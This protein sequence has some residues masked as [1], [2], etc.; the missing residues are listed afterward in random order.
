MFSKKLWQKAAARLKDQGIDLMFFRQ[1]SDPEGLNSR[2]TIHGDVFMGEVTKALPGFRQVLDQARSFEHRMLLS[3]EG[4]DDFSSFTRQETLKV[5][6]YLNLP[7][8]NNFINAM[9]FIASLCNIPVSFNDPETVATCGVYHPSANTWFGTA[10]E[11]MN[12]YISKKA[13]F[14]PF[15]CAGIVCAYNQIIEENTKEIDALI[16]ILETN[17]LIPF[18][19]F[20]RG[21]AHAPDSYDQQSNA[22]SKNPYDWMRLFEAGDI[23]PDILLNLLAGRFLA[24]PEDGKFLNSL[25]IP[26][27]QLIKS[28]AHSVDQWKADPAGLKSHSMIYSLSQPEMNGVIEPTMA[29]CVEDPGEGARTG[30][31]RFE[32][33]QERLESLVKRIRRWRILQKKANH[34]KKITIVLH[35]NPCKGVEST[36]GMAVGLDT[37][38]S[39]GATI[40]ALG[41]A[42]YDIKDCPV[43][44]LALKNAVFEKKAFSEFR[45]TTVDEIVSKG[46]GLH[47]MGADEYQPY[48]NGLPKAAKEKIEK[49][50][51]PFPGQG[52][53]YEKQDRKNLV[54][55]GLCFGNLK[56]MVQPKRGC[57][58]AKCNGEVCR[59]LHEPDLSPPHHWLASYKFIRDTSDAVLHFGAEGALEYLPG[60]RAALCQTCFPDISLGDLPNI[61]VYCMDI[62]GE[63]LMAKRRAQAV[64]VD[65]LSPVL[66][67]MGAD[68][69]LIELE[70]LLAQYQKA[71]Q[72][73]ESD[74]R[75]KLKQKMLPLMA[76][77]EP[78]E[79]KKGSDDFEDRLHTLGRRI[80]QLKTACFQSGLHVL[81]KAPDEEDMNA[82]LETL[83]QTVRDDDLL[84][85]EKIFFITEK[86][87]QC[88]RE[89]EAVVQCLDGKYLE[90]GLGGSFY[91]GKL[92]TLPTGRNFYPVDIA[93]LPTKTAWETGKIMADKLLEKYFTQE[94]EFPENVG[95]SLWSSDAFKADGELFSQ[96]LYLLGVCPV[97]ADNGRVKGLDVIET[98]RL[99]LTTANHETIHRPRVDVTIQTS[100]ILRDMVPN[101]CDLMD[102]AV[103]MVSRLDEPS[104]VNYVAKRTREQILELKKKLGKDLPEEAIARMACF[105]VFSSKPGTYGLG[106]GLALDASAWKNKNDLAEAYVNWGGYAYGSEKISH[107]LEN[108]GYEAHA[109]LAR[110]L[111]D[112]DISYMK[113][114]CVEYDVLDC[115]GYAVFQGGMATAGN[116]LKKTGKKI[117]LYWGSAGT[118]E[119]KGICDLKDAIENSALTKLL[120]KDWL[121]KIKPHGFQAASSIASKINNL[122]KLAATTESVDDWLFDRVVDTYIADEANAAWMKLQN[123][124][125]VEELTRRLLEAHSRK[126]WEPDDRRLELVQSMALE[127]EGDMEETMGEVNSE[128]QGSRVDVMTKD[129]VE[130]WNPAFILAGS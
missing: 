55:T 94:G 93:A 112:V 87:Q 49:D 67:H 11:Y 99:L 37:F 113:Q 17:D 126:L 7:H 28:Y 123:P 44:G 110:Q 19:V 68:E 122:F 2:Q 47:F 72:L 56:I 81:G 3:E 41:A 82:M 33:V 109:I 114:S 76:E 29:A 15:G 9:L 59:I 34:E 10:N 86:L 78:D 70:S 103:V 52:M 5:H 4:A 31:Y 1:G 127:I 79:N 73:E 89:L 83:E 128:F 101:F 40:R 14:I 80:R 95:I 60:K 23:R 12:W 120:N 58:G 63:G 24:R 64:I 13:D 98:D 27:I 6:E 38:E 84:A 26:V 104:D 85:R 61:Y 53:V 50:W 107:A 88:P 105:R 115:G 118:G 117:K 21:E 124:Y 102:E 77:L 48:F 96:I 46:G 75:Q 8:E 71:D 51:G 125:A 62:P 35:N 42:G 39:L 69:N 57:Y 90:A 25:N 20:T 116:A 65:H 36:V 74:R 108:Y 111:R 18:C 100:G 30:E 91:Q 45:W 66:S 54:I 106:V 129:D 92:E 22:T 43:E 97:W 130:N 121:E 16:R 119:E 32:P